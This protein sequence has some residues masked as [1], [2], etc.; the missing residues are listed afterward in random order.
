[1][2]DRLDSDTLR[3]VRDAARL[4]YENQDALGLDSQAIKLDTL[5]ADIVA[6]LEI[7]TEPAPPGVDQPVP[8]PDPPAWRRWSSRA[9]QGN[10]ART[11]PTRVPA[12]AGVPPQARGA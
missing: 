10:A 4:L 7:R 9:P 1:M 2:F 11:A 3:A 6:E 12:P 8:V 5:A